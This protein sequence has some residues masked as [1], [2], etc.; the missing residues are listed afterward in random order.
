MALYQSSQGPRVEE[1]QFVHALARAE[2]F[3]EWLRLFFI[4]GETYSLVV[5]LSGFSLGVRQKQAVKAC[6][7]KNLITNGYPSSG[8]KLKNIA[9]CN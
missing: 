3:L 8:E 5:V 4:R 1:G 9:H 2:L 7:A 6:S